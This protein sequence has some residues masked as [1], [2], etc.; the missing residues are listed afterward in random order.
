MAVSDEGGNRSVV[1]TLA[2]TR[3]ARLCVHKMQ[4]SFCLSLPTGTIDAH[5][6]A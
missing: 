4:S 2:L 5:Y 3:L 1:G 6:Q